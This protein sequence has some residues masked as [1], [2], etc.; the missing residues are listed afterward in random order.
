[1]CTKPFT[2]NWK[3]YSQKSIPQQHISIRNSDKSPNHF[4]H[5]R[6]KVTDCLCLWQAL[7]YHRI[8]T[9]CWARTH[10]EKWTIFYSSVNKP[11]SN[12]HGRQCGCV[13]SQAGAQQAGLHKLHFIKRGQQMFSLPL[14]RIQFGA[15]APV[16]GSLCSLL[17]CGD[18]NFNLSSPYS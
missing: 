1:M 17:F 11:L 9:T 10:H 12:F 4:N 6:K 15:A 8:K 14:E 18:D 7:R 16:R 5:T 3:W 2:A 13:V